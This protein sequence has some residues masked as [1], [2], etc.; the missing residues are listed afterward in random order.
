[1]FFQAIA[2][3]AVIAVAA[4]A[5]LP[6]SP[7]ALATIQRSEQVVNPGILCVNLNVFAFSNKNSFH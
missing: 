5:I 1:M 2:F 6:G 3:F 7:E 4:A